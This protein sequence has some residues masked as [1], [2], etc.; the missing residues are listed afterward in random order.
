MILSLISGFVSLNK[1]NCFYYIF[2]C[3]YIGE[4]ASNLMGKL[5][6]MTL[7]LVLLIYSLFAAQ[8]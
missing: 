5:V 3:V 4:P 2:V 1:I 6:K 7:F 8:V